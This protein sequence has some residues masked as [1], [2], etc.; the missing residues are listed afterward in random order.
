V[1]WLSQP[2]FVKLVHTIWNDPRFLVEGNKQ[3]RLVSKL[4]ELKI[5]TKKWIKDFKTNEHLFLVKLETDIEQLLNKIV[6]T[7]LSLE[8]ERQTGCAGNK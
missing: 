7:P 1:D 2:D 3:V 8:E 6:E 4:K 5:Q